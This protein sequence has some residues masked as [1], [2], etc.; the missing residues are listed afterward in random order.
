[1]SDAD[2]LNLYPAYPTYKPSRPRVAAD[3]FNSRPFVVSWIFVGVRV[4]TSSVLIYDCHQ[5][6]GRGLPHS[7]TL[8]R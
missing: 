3:V 7:T 6:S 4:A 2:G 1:M 5:E 8:A